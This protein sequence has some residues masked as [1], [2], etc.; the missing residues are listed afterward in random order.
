VVDT[1]PGTGYEVGVHGPRD[2]QAGLVGGDVDRRVNSSRVPP[3]DLNHVIAPFRRPSD[4][5]ALRAF[6]WE[7]P[8]HVEIGFG[9]AHHICGLAEGEPT[10]HVLGFETKRPWCRGAARRAERL[11]LA[12]LRVIEGDA[13]PYMQRLLPDGCVQMVHVLFPDPWWKRRHHKRRLF[14]E[15]FVESVHRL[16]APGGTLVTKTDVAP[17]ADLIEEALGTHAG[18]SL[19][20]TTSLDPVLAAL[21]LSHREKKCRELG[22]SVFQYRYV[23]EI[24]T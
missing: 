11:G 15:T 4:E 20:A 22:I 8:V 18:F 21:P 6:L 19:A 24:G 10:L 9:R 3:L 13:R 16:L 17:Y 12:N 23:K 1:R 7:A 5:E 2:I 14:S